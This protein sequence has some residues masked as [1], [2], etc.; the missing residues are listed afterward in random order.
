MPTVFSVHVFTSLDYFNIP[1][2][3]L[4]TASH[5][6][7]IPL[8]TN[9]HQRNQTLEYLILQILLD[10]S[11]SLSLSLWAYTVKNYF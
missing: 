9:I 1:F 6:D 8:L 10:D 2:R 7:I 11:L 4:C 3:L 5:Y